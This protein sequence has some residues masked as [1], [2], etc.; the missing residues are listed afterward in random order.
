ME[1][2]SETFA[3]AVIHNQVI[4]EKMANL[5]SFNLIKPGFRNN[6]EK[7]FVFYVQGKDSFTL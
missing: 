3:R 2:Q 6:I 4:I 1:F 5:D 7:Q